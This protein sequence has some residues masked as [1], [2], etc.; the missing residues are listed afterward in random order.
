MT[1]LTASLRQL[2]Q[3][4]A[5]WF[6]YVVGGMMLLPWIIFAF[7]GKLVSSSFFPFM[8]LVTNLVLGMTAASLVREVLACPFSVCLPGRHRAD[9]RFL[10]VVGW[11]S[12]AILAILFLTSSAAGG[13]PT[14]LLYVVSAVFGVTVFLISVWVA[15]LT[16]HASQFLGFLP[17]VMLVMHLGGEHAW[18]EMLVVQ[19]WP[20]V[21]L[22]CAG[23][24]V[25]L[26]TRAAT[27]AC[28]G[29]LLDQP[30]LGMLGA[31]NPARAKAYRERLTT[32]RLAKGKGQD[33]G[34][35]GGCF[36]GMVQRTVPFT[37]HKAIASA[38]FEVY[39][40]LRWRHAMGPVAAGIFFLGYAFLFEGVMGRQ[41][42]T[43]LYILFIVP[44]VL[45]IHIPFP[46]DSS[47]LLPRT[48][49][50]R[51]WATLV[52]LL[53]GTVVAIVSVCCIAGV[54][55]WLAASVPVVTV[56]GRE[57]AFVA[58]SAR[59]WPVTLLVIPI[60]CLSQLLLPNNF[61]RML[62]F[63][64]MFPIAMLWLSLG[65]TLPLGWVFMA[66][67]AIWAG[68][69]V[70]LHRHCLRACLGKHA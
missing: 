32:A 30:F 28:A 39:G 63:M 6:L 56:R 64:L 49:R 17:L 29:R 51:F 27:R 23:L 34:G 8:L 10:L 58:V 55:Q 60:G 59:L 33:G 65:A 40:A 46:C 68:F 38:C 9:G 11:G 2:Y 43:A 19:G 61:L 12:N 4:R 14:G 53:V 54:S 47:S 57:L 44:V 15:Y 36:E 41:R 1:P 52:V 66:A 24:H 62:P 18:L 20:M 25:W 13:L 26:I 3:R 16:P 22:C 7:Q 37:S 31:F 70:L 48:R 5:L 21:L 67:L 50:Q 45:G 35:P 69:A 42:A